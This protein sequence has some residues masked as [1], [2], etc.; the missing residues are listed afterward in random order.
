MSREHDQRPITDQIPFRTV[1]LQIS[2]RVARNAAVV[3]LVPGVAKQYN[4]L[5]LVD[6][7]SAERGDGARD[8]GCSLA[9]VVR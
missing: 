8:Q 3:L 6:D 2:L 5:D 7:C 1:N 9:V 4:A